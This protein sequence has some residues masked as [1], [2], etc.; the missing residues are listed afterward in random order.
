MTSKSK[1]ELL[2]AVRLRCLKANKSEK[3][4]NLDRA[5][6]GGLAAPAAP[7]GAERLRYARAWGALR[8]RPRIAGRGTGG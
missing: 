3:A 4:H 1:R 6:P 8:S 2:E 5:P 7:T